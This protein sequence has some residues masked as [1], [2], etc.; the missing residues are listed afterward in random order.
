MVQYSGTGISNYSDDSGFTPIMS[1]IFFLYKLMMMISLIT[2]LTSSTKE[3]SN[4]LESM[5]RLGERV[6]GPNENAEKKRL[7][8]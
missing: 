3:L 2:F 1:L 6:T 5:K 4:T 8:S 7:W